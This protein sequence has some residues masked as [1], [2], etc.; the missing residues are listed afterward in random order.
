[1]FAVT[2]ITGKV[3]AAVARSLLA[4]D[5]ACASCDERSQ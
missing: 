2:G 1:M 4:A 3:G 5:Q